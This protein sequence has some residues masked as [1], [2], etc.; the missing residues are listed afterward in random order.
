M[1][2]LPHIIHVID[3]STAGGVTGVVNFICQSE[4]LARSAQHSVH[5][6]ARGKFDTIP[7]NVDV[8]VSHTVISWRTL[9]ALIALRAL[10]PSTP[11]VHV[12]HSYTAGFETHRVA[13][14]KRFLGLL[15]VGFSLF[16]RV[17]AVS[18]AQ[19]EWF[20]LRD[21]CSPD[22][23]QVIA[24][25]VDL[26]EFRTLPSPVGKPRVLGAIGRLD[27]QKGFDI[28]IGAFRAINDPSLELR[29]IGT[30]AQDA[31]LRNLAGQDKR[32]TFVGHVD[33]PK[34]AMR[35]VDAVV[36]PSRWEALGL[37]ALEA[38]AAERPLLCS[39]VDGLK[40]HRQKGVLYIQGTN[41]AALSEAIEG[42]LGA[43]AKNNISG[44]SKPMPETTFKEAWEHLVADLCVT[45][46][47]T[48]TVAA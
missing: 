48:Y 21:L 26:S 29:I 16:D 32:I 18:N 5:I 1:I 27:A 35:C 43:S 7:K 2:K 45:R 25:C 17:I 6:V 31:Q 24:S 40:D 37:V 30:G 23:L 3:D 12:E 14:P 46:T 36:M 47:S 33:D 19:A 44:V 42:L 20:K 13:R 28:L 38:L 8:I 9:P 4:Q 34:E 41:E 39:D 15:K 22:R 11:I 10:R